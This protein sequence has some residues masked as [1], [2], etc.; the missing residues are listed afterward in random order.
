MTHGWQAIHGKPSKNWFHNKEFTLKMMDCGIVCASNG[1][2]SGVGDPFVYFLKK[3]GIVFNDVTRSKS[4]YILKIPTMAK[5]K[6]CSKLKKWSCGCT[7]V[8]VAVDE[9]KARCL[10][11]GCEFE[12]SL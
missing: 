3:H 12:L 1:W 11:C 8:R 7:N 6:G 4:D 9:F 10:I 5:L 2:H